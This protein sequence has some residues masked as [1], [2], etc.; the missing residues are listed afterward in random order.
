M[1]ES[2][3]EIYISVYTWGKTVRRMRDAKKCKKGDPGA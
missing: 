3:T 1:K 2:T